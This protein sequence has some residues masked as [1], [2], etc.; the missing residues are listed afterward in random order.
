[1]AYVDLTVENITCILNVHV[2]SKDVRFQVPK[3]MWIEL[4]CA[5][6]K[7]TERDMAVFANESNINW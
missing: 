1:M 4:L 3:H 5:G 7:S 2:F 6:E